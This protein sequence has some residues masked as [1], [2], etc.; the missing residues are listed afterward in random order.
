MDLSQIKPGLKIKTI[1]KLEST[2]GMLISDSYLKNRVANKPGVIKNWVPGH[3][4][5]V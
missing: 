4:G 2:A 3:G 1:K 5:D